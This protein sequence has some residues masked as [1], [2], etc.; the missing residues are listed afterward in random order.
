MP[1]GWTKE[2]EIEWA[3]GNSFRQLLGIE[4]D[5]VDDGYA[6]LLLPVAEHLLQAAN[7]VHGGVLAAFVDGAIGTVVR[8]VIPEGASA[9]TVE[10]NISYLRPAGKGVLAAEARIV[11]AGRTVIVG[12]AEV[13]DSSGRMVAVGRASYIASRAGE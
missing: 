8:T 6:R 13:K 12:T 10:L 4:V 1:A 2:R 11:R 9:S 5:A 3:R 7:V